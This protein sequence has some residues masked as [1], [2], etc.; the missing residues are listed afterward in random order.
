MPLQGEPSGVALDACTLLNLAGAGLALPE[1][2]RVLRWQLFV[3]EQVVAE[4]LWIEDVVEGKPVRLPVDVTQQ[5]GP[6]VEVVP[7]TEEELELFVAFAATVDDG[8]AAT[9]A[10]A[11]AR[12]LTLLTDDRKARRVAGRANVPVLGTSDLLRRWTG[13]QRTPAVEVAA[14]LRSVE[15]RARFT[16]PRDD[17]QH[18]WWAGHL[19]L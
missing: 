10:I 2:A 7:L 6:G 18:T 11:G 9:L 13:E 14:L 17:P 16:P 19:R 15:R 12:H 8:E 5:Q 4:T 3:P 1:V